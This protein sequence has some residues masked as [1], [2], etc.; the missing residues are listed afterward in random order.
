MGVAG[1][2]AVDWSDAAGGV[3]D[4]VVVG[5]VDELPIWD[6]TKA[7]TMTTARIATQAIQPEPLREAGV[8]RRSGR[9]LL[10]LGS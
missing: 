7:P 1:A 9:V 5:S 10:E 6:Q 4:E 8:V 2:G 3:V